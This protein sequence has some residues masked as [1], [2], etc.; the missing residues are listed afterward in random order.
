MR[1]ALSGRVVEAPQEKTHALIDVVEL[2]ERAAEIGYEGLEIRNS[3]L[4]A[5]APPERVGEI[6]EA[7]TQNRLEACCLVADSAVEG[8][9]TPRFDEYLDLGLRIGAR[10][11]RPSIGSV[12]Q[13]PLAQAAADRAAAHGIELVQFTHHG[14]PFDSPE[15]CIW[16]L[17]RVNRR[18][19]GLVFEAA[20]LY[21]E[22]QPCGPATIRQ[23]APY[24]LHA[25]CQN[26]LLCD[27]GLPIQTRAGPAHY[28]NLRIDDP[29]GVDVASVVQGLKEIGYDGWLVLHS[30][31]L[32]SV[33]PIAYATEGHAFLRKL[34]EAP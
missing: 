10:R 27:D 31:R 32:D 19:V 13:I 15:R 26:L 23:L 9:F 3:Q 2:A 16:M 7:L 18:N 24:I 33:D 25:E 11:I 14:T 20:N 1:L 8:R 5:G 12:E 30:P 28:R 4:D 6:A 29:Q 21:M 22:R 17:Q 34:I